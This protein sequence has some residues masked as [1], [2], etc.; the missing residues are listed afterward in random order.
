VICKATVP[1]APEPLRLPKSQ[2]APVGRPPQENWIA[3]LEKFETLTVTV[4]V[5][6]GFAI[7]TLFELKLTEGGGGEATVIDKPAVAVAGVGSESVTCTT[8]LLVPACVGVPVIAPVVAAS[9][10]PGGRVPEEMLQEYG[11]IPPVADK[12]AEYESPTVAFGR[13]EFVTMSGEGATVMDKPAVAVAGV[14]S[15]SVTCT[16]KL[17]VPAWVGVPVIAPVPSLSDSPGGS[18]PEAMLQV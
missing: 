3:V 17:L 18:V 8:K 2:D 4:P 1:E 6:P 16:T 5:A 15:E 7:V 11:P 14:G 13:L 12:V 9:D 10:S